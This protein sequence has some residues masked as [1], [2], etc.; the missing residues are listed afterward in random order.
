MNRRATQD[1]QILGKSQTIST[2]EVT[3]GMEEKPVRENRQEVEIQKRYEP[4]TGLRF[5]A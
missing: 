3:T 2:Q 5:L 1:R 4:K